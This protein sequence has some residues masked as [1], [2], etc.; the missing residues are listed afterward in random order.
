M[1]RTVFVFAMLMTATAQAYQINFCDFTESSMKECPNKSV[2][3]IFS[4]AEKDKVKNNPASYYEKYRGATNCSFYTFT[5]GSSE[6]LNTKGLAVEKS[7]SEYWKFVRAW[8]NPRDCKIPKTMKLFDSVNADHTW[9]SMRLFELHFGKTYEKKDG[10]RENRLKDIE[11][12]L[13]EVED[14]FKID[15]MLNVGTDEY[16]YE[17]AKN[18]GAYTAVVGSWV[19][20]LGGGLYMEVEVIDYSGLNGG[21]L[22]VTVTD[23]AMKYLAEA[24]RWF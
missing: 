16:C 8:N 20:H 15:A 1:N 13:K 21:S 10:W 4:R 19:Y 9:K 23:V 7:S 2:R 5:F 11:T 22:C 12:F 3:R 17:R 24:E 18:K 6:F 14:K